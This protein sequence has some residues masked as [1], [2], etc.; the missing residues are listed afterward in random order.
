MEPIRSLGTSMPGWIQTSLI[1]VILAI[2][3]SFLMFVFGVVL[4]ATVVGQSERMSPEALKRAKDYASAV[5]IYRDTYGVAHVF[6][7]TD[8]SVVFGF[9]YARAEDEFQR[10]HRSLII[11]SGRAS[12]LLGE[13]GFSSDRGMKLFEVEK[14]ARA[15]FDSYEAPFQKILT[16][17]SDALNF[18][19]VNHPTESPIIIEQFEPWHLLA[20]SRGMNIS[21]LLLS[22]EYPSL[23]AKAVRGGTGPPTRTDGVRSDRDGSNMWAIGPPLSASG[24]AMLFINP[25]IPLQEVYEGHL[26]SDEG[27]NIAGGFSYGA[28][29]TPFAGHNEK[30]GWSLTVN[31]PD[32]V[33]VYVEEFEFESD[34]LKYKS[35]GEWR[36]AT[37]WDEIIKI[38]RGDR[39]VEKKIECVKTHHGPVFLFEG[40]TGYVISIPKLHEGGLTR[41]FFD[42]A[43]AQNLAD[44]K[45]AV[46]RLALVYH[47]VMYADV[48]GNTWY[49]YN[50]AMPRR[51]E[52]VDWS[53]PVS[54]DDPKTE[55]SD[56]HRLDELPQVLNP[57]CGWMQN[58]NS[59]PF[60]TTAGNQNPDRSRFPAYMGVADRDNSRVAISK[61]ILAQGKKLTFEDLEAAAWDKQMLEADVWMPI[62]AKA[63]GPDSQVEKATLDAARPLYDELRKWDRQCQ[64][65][66]VAAT[67]F[68]FW[69][70][71]TGNQLDSKNADLTAVAKGLENVKRE[72]DTA[73]GT[74]R[75][76]YG[77]VFRHQRPTDNGQWP[78]DTAKSLPIASGSPQLGIV[79]CFVSRTVGQSKRRYG[80]HGH[81]YVSIVEFD[82]KGVRALSVT[83]YGQ[84]RDPKS[85]H[86]FD[87]AELYAAGKFKPAWFTLEEIKA[88]LERHYHPGG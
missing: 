86:Y 75:V 47:N 35:N 81:S 8:A 14:H 85:P 69:H 23:R 25:H 66:S 4:V 1:T 45:T 68:A 57:E 55:W 37:K 78:G 16:A 72:L 20:A 10:I 24:N 22:P 76:P 49:V 6:G 54:G 48:K 5:T 30:L 28:F 39:L 33:D 46:S 51:D 62:M 19:V 83:P 79:S 71:S 82:P 87:Q 3:S 26:H 29:L 36:T 27:L 88:N 58:C 60:S 7:P 9:T 11:G 56:Y 40:K 80:F 64:I 61:H 15:E 18:Y 50:S 43:V 42:M 2:R 34:E 13:A 53:R 73:F 77:D 84:S 67:V 59:S 63:F 74:W 12:E 65:E 70:E 31:Y 52:S 41:Q 21:I 44:F 38:K 17:Y 32:V